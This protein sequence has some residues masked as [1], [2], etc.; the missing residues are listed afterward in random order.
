MAVRRILYLITRSNL[1]GAQTNVLDLIGGFHPRYAVE[2]ASGEEG[3]LT[4]R[5]RALGVPVHPLPY[6]LRRVDPRGDLRSVRDCTALIRARKPDLVHAHSSKAGIVGRLAGRLAGV[7]VVFTAHGWGFSSGA[8][9]LRR[10]LALLSE[11]AVA[12]LGAQTICVSEDDRQ[13][14]LRLRVGSARSLTTVHLGLDAGAGVA[15]DP[16]VQPPRFVMV[17]RFNEQKDQPT[18]LR[19]IARVRRAGTCEAH[20]DFVGS[21]PALERCRALAETLSVSASVSFLGDRHDVPDLL[22]MAQGCILST[23]YEGLP[24]SILEAMRAG[25]PVLATAVNGIPEEV[26]DGQTGLLVPPG[27]ADALAV[28]LQ[29]LIGSP[30]LRRRMGEAGRQRFL[31][32]FTL[33][34]MLRETEAVYKRASPPFGRE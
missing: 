30:A 1:G 9:P 34:R 21:G 31:D 28:S 12:R 18:L 16:A 8:P 26:I 23:H 2:L 29:T 32:E 11:K 20:F 6:L 13:R 25:L 3:P 7:P 19:A 24:F 10:A 17:A 27:D 22:A 4:A 5:A 33:D 15:A 14:A